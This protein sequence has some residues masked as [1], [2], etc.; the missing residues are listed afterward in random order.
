M[1]G[2][3]DSDATARTKVCHR[4]NRSSTCC[5]VVRLHLCKCF[6]ESLVGFNQIFFS[7][8]FD[9]LDD[10]R[11]LLPKLLLQLAGHLFS[12]LLQLDFDFVFNLDLA[13]KIDRRVLSALNGVRKRC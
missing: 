6:R 4:R 11:G 5:R 8:R 1:L 3:S 7:S 2:I 9:Q 12:V 10:L 13:V